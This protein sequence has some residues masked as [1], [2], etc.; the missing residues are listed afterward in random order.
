MAEPNRME[1]WSSASPAAEFEPSF[2]DLYRE[3]QLP[4]VRLAWR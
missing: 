3:L 2:V 1:E 4:M